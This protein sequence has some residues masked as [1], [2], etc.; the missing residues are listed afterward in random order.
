MKPKKGFTLI[1]LLVV[2]AIIAIL[3]ALI[4]VAL[5]TARQK[6]YRAKAQSDMNSIN[7][8]IQL[9]ADDN[10]GNYP[11]AVDWGGLMAAL[12]PTY[13]AV[14]TAPGGVTYTGSS[15]ATTYTITA[16]WTF[17]GGGAFTCTQTG[18][19]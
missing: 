19:S 9:Y 18:C 16:T 8:M 12:T 11:T 15:T 6:S 4:I 14:P 3:A 5:N 7:T 2:I 17:L 10:N 1:E 13:G